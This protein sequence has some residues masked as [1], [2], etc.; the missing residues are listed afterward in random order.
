MLVIIL[1]SQEKIVVAV[2]CMH[3]K[4]FDLMVKKCNR[5]DRLLKAIT[6]IVKYQKKEKEL[7][8]YRVRIYFFTNFFQIYYLEITKLKKQFCTLV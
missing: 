1:S 5:F 3:H 6:T 4:S 8:W 2:S 7:K